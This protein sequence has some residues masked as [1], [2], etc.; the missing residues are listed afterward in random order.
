MYNCFVG[1][2]CLVVLFAL[3]EG[4]EWM[5]ECSLC[6]VFCVCVLCWF[7][8]CRSVPLCCYILDAQHIHCI[9]KECSTSRALL[10]SCN[11]EVLGMT[12]FHWKN[13][14]RK[15]EGGEGEGE[16]RIYKEEDVGGRCTIVE[17]SADTFRYNDE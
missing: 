3:V 11:K 4:S 10:N 2:M 12:K 8:C 16:D 17:R 14:S 6:V 13:Q 7:F 1:L 5:W 9:Y 15:K